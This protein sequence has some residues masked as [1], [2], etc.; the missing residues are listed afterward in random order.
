MECNHYPKLGKLGHI[1]IGTNSVE[2]A[3]FQLERKG[4]KFNHEEY[5]SMKNGKVVAIYLEQ[6]FGG[7]A[8]HLVQK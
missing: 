2:R 8:V 5:K 4:V 6:E 3:M 7:F 1:A